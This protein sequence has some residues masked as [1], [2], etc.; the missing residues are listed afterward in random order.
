MQFLVFHIDKLNYAIPIDLVDKIIAVP[1]ISTYPDAPIHIEGLINYR[2]KIY[3]IVNLNLKLDQ[4][5][6]GI[7]EYSKIIILNS[8][9]NAGFMIDKTREIINIDESTISYD[10]QVISTHPYK[11]IE[12]IITYK[13][14]TIYLLDTTSILAKTE[15][16]KSVC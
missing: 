15:K 5:F 12:G 4:N 10:K 11:Y 2:S 8:K 3:A 7:T 6:N 13:Q 1:Q 9:I 16:I 14:S